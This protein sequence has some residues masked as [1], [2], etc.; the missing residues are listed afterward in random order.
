MSFSCSA[1]QK[2]LQ[3]Q[4]NNNQ[5]CNFPS[6]THNLLNNET[7]FHNSHVTG[8]FG[9]DYEQQIPSPVLPL[10][11]AENCPLPIPTQIP[12]NF[13]NEQNFS[14]KLQK[15]SPYEQFTKGLS[16]CFQHEY[17]PYLN[18][19]GTIAASSS[20][21]RSVFAGANSSSV[22]GQ[23]KTASGFSRSKVKKHHLS[24][25]SSFTITKNL[26]KHSQSLPIEKANP[27]FSSEPQK[28]EKTVVAG[29]AD[30]ED[31]SLQKMAGAHYSGKN[32]V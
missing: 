1:H 13:Q 26:L 16:H 24:E 9:A 7:F 28:T 6:T 30:R 10:P 23:R 12:R 25:I 8:Q 11:R 20:V 14:L 5:P 15:Q 4:I 18:I 3:S 27:V 32:T 31:S 22:K 19:H 2:Q 17:L 29:A 21:E